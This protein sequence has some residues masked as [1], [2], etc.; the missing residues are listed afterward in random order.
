MYQFINIFIYIYTIAMPKSHKLQTE[1][2]EHWIS[3]Q[4]TL[5]LTPTSAVLQDKR[6]LHFSGPIQ[7]NQMPPPRVSYLPGVASG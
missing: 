7:E 6:K 2:E 5:H 4:L 1:I 3:S